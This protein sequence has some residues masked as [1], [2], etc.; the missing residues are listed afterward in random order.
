[1]KVMRDF[2]IP[3][4]RSISTNLME[5]ME[6]EG[7]G[8]MDME[9][10]A[11]FA[12]FPMDRKLTANELEK[13]RDVVKRMKKGKVKLFTEAGLPRKIRLSKD[14]LY[15]NVEDFSGKGGGG[16]K[17]I[18][19]HRILKDTKHC[20]TSKGCRI[21]MVALCSSNTNKFLDVKESCEYRWHNSLDLHSLE[22]PKKRKNLAE[23]ASDA[24]GTAVALLGLQ[25]SK[26]RRKR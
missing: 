24:V 15:A 19:C 26:R 1:M 5:T 2:Q 18:L 10:G 6:N 23:K 21:C 3:S 14:Y 4:Y 25:R 12:D 9:P 8:C 16:T 11:R 7:G 22:R 20:S 13:F 17:C